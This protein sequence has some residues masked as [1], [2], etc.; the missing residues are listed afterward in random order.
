MS[1]TLSYLYYQ[2]TQSSSKSKY[3][4]LSVLAIILCQLFLLFLISITRNL[5]LVISHVSL[6][7]E[8]MF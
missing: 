3:K 7:D 2:E 6:N 5:R 4:T 1:G 8:D